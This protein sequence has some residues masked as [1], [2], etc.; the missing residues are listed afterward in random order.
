VAVFGKAVTP[1]Q[2]YQISKFVRRIICFDNE[3]DTQEQAKQ[4]CRELSIFSG[5]TINVCLDA[6]DPGSASAD[7][8]KRL[9]RLFLE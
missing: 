6:A 5:E 4:L 3:P 8:I 7:E 2:K 9:R 1:A